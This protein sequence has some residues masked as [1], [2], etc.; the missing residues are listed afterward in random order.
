MEQVIRPPLD[1]ESF[2][3]QI[4][5][6]EAEDLPYSCPDCGRSC[7]TMD[8]VWNHTRM[9]EKIKLACP[10]LLHP[11]LKEGYENLRAY[12][13]MRALGRYR[14]AGKSIIHLASLQ[15]ANEELLADFAMQMVQKMSFLPSDIKTR[16]KQDYVQKKA[17]QFYIQR[18]CQDFLS[19]KGA[20]HVVAWSLHGNVYQ[21]WTNN[22][23]M[24]QR[25]QL[26]IWSDLTG[27]PIEG[28]RMCW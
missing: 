6:M 26:H 23:S 22:H 12:D 13:K 16:L 9:G 7:S 10:Q 28:R 19:G 25:C 3:C 24:K 18:S 8:E 17:T 4:M 2:Q 27:E 15:P 5:D 21:G 1:T 11:R 20:G 14:Y